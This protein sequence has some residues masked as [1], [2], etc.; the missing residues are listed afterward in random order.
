M[1]KPQSPRT[2][3]KRKLSNGLESSPSKKRRAGLDNVVSA[4]S[5]YNRQNRYLNPL[6]RKMINDLKGTSPETLQPAPVSKALDTLKR[7]M[8]LK[9][10]SPKVI[11]KMKNEPKTEIVMYK[12]KKCSPDKNTKR[13]FFA[14]RSPNKS[15]RK[16][17]K[18]SLDMG[19]NLQIQF[20]NVRR[21]PRKLPPGAIAEE[22]V[23]ESM[24]SLFS[25]DLPPTRKSPNKFKS[26]ESLAS[27]RRSP[28]KVLG[29]INSTAKLSV[30][31][32]C[33]AMQRLSPLPESDA[34][35]GFAEESSSNATDSPVKTHIGLARME[36]Q[37]PKVKR[38]IFVF[39]NIYL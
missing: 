11:Q 23:D 13:K 32:E 16:S 33:E 2:P 10:K 28:R 19:R 26:M 25:E 1:R 31:A 21:S 20:S 24:L 4:K 12:K 38:L 27:V 5:F 15:P 22:N 9:S 30:I 29:Q 7:S 18:M 14:K 39:L 34:E 36:P 8:K 37:S 6:E 35:S 17:H 3:S